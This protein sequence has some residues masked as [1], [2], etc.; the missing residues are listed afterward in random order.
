MDSNGKERGNEEGKSEWVGRE[1]RERLEESEKYL[2]N[3]RVT[4]HSYS[5]K[6]VKFVPIRAPRRRAERITQKIY[7][8]KLKCK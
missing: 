3:F 4:S 7:T 6:F 2:V 8:F 1:A 5:C